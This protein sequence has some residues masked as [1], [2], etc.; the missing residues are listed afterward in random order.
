MAAGAAIRAA[1][2]PGPSSRLPRRIG[3]A[4]DDL[5]MMEPALARSAAWGRTKEDSPSGLWR[6]PGTRVGL[7]ALG[8]SNPPSSAGKPRDPSGSGAFR[9]S[10]PILAAPLTACV[11]KDVGKLPSIPTT[12]RLAGRAG[13]GDS[14]QVPQGDQP[15][16]LRA[17]PGEGL[18]RQLEFSLGT[19]ATLTDARGLPRRPPGRRR[20]MSW[21]P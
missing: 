15:H 14:T 6:T 7:T 9:M 2:R 19:F 13:D 10:R 16:P 21:T 1:G 5:V 11:C 18:R 20:R 12:S 3:A 4:Q 17:V 8:G